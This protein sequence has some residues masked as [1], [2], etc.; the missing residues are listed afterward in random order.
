[1]ENRFEVE[2]NLFESVAFYATKSVSKNNGELQEIRVVKTDKFG[3]HRVGIAFDYNKHGDDRMMT[4]IMWPSHYLTPDEEV[5]LDMN[6]NTIA[7]VMYRINVLIN[8]ETGKPMNDAQP[9]AKWYAWKD[10]NGEWHR[11]TGARVEFKD[12]SDNAQ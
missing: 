1:M 6:S 4:L 8:P 9:S 5:E 12:L 2:G 7:E 11:P 3:D 10:C